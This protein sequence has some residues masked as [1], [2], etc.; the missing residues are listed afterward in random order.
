MRAHRK[1]FLTLAILLFAFT[2]CAAEKKPP[3]KGMSSKDRPEISQLEPRGIQRGTTATIKLI[4]TNLT[5]LTGLTLPTPKLTGKLL[6]QPAPTTN[7]AWIEITAPAD[8]SRDAYEI[9]V[10][11]ADQESGKVKLYVDDLPQVY[12][13]ELK[14]SRAG[15]LLLQW[16]A[17]L[18]GLLD[19]PGDTDEVAF[20]AK[21]GDSLVFDLAARNIGSK[22]SASLALF[23]AKGAWVASDSGFDG[24]DPLLHFKVPAS[25]RYRLRI[26]DQTASGSKDHFYRLSAGAFPYVVA[27][28]PL[29][30]AANRETE[31]ELIG[32]NL[33]AKSGALI[34]AGGP[35]E[36][37]VPVDANKFRSR[38]PL[39]A[40]VG[41]GVELVESEPNDSPGQAMS[42]VVP[43]TVCGRI[44]P[45]AKSRTADADWFRF[46]ARA[47]QT[48]VIETE[49]AR[50]NSPVDTK[51]EILH[52]DGRPVE[53]LILQAVRDSRL[54]YRAIDSATDDARVENWQE[55][56]LGQ[57]L[58]LQGE[59]CRIFRMP[60]GPDSGFQFFNVANKRR[61]Y[62][63]TS[64]TAHALDEP[65]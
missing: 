29:S 28:F 54:T 44:W 34:K 62:F 35:G 9:A 22:A 10:R 60:Q 65:A 48:W 50:R 38:R 53:R 14:K 26:A 13:E 58:Y 49:A 46:E 64:P 57:F 6:D 12:E 8:L 2:V 18:W 25:G 32:F 41:D 56:E 31:V 63:G 3:K 36:T 7:E 21:A 27:F 55:T 40:V 33:P 43:S 45:A 24:G 11:N 23:D 51:I 5:G 19:H 1:P 47:G 15:K 39:K 4:G 52:A 61:C 16:P 37:P 42:I 30:V 59:V 17:T 20:D